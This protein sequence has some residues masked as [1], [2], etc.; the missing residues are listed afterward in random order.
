MLAA[1]FHRVGRRR[2]T[3]E[4]MH[5]LGAKRRSRQLALVREQF[6][7]GPTPESLVMATVDAANI[8]ERSLIEAASALGVR[9]ASE[10]S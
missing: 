5:A 10:S 3:C 8:P 9:T 4:R 1:I 6:K 2:P 7:H